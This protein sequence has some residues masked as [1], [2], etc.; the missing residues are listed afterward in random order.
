MFL[1]ATAAY[2]SA[3][4]PDNSETRITLASDERPSSVTSVRNPSDANSAK[5]PSP[6]VMRPPRVVVCQN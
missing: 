1:K 2:A 3:P 4:P 5:M 6:M